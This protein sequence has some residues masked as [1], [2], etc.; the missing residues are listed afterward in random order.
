[1]LRLLSLLMTLLALA[2]LLRLVVL[3]IPQSA[4]IDGVAWLIVGG[5]TSVVLLT[6]PL[7]LLALVIGLIS[8]RANATTRRQPRADHPTTA[9]AAATVIDQEVVDGEII[10]GEVIDCDPLVPER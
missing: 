5:I 4:L 3:H 2:L 6:P 7:A 8:L 1:M 10:D 9:H